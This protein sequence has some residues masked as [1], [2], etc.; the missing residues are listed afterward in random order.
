MSFYR[1]R[2]MVK[3]FEWKTGADLN[4]KV[5]LITGD[6]SSIG[7]LTAE[8]F[9]KQNVRVV[10]NSTDIAAGMRAL[11]HLEKLDGGDVAF[12]PGDITKYRDCR[13]V[14]SQTVETFGRLDVAINL[15]GI[16]LEKPQATFIAELVVPELR[17]VGGGAIFDIINYTRQ[18]GDA[19]W[20]AQ[21]GMILAFAKSMNLE[22]N[23]YDIGINC[24]TANDAALPLLEQLIHDKCM[25]NLLPTG[26][27]ASPAEVAR[28]IS[29]LTL[30]V[31]AIISGHGWASKDGLSAG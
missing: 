30:A 27:K 23:P 3:D 21:Y 18:A 26:R 7:F 14:V 2:Q 16:Y 11:E 28:I 29:V 24:V 22:L 25:K 13:Q 6:A 31:T 20:L 19:S 9:T 12:V 17:K 5:V 4:D 10:I 8:Q 15:T 1:F